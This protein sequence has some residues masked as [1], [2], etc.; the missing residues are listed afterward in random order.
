MQCWLSEIAAKEIVLLLADIEINDE[1]TR[2]Y[3]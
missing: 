1:S 3:N 2:F